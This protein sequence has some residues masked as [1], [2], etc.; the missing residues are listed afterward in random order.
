MATKAKTTNTGNKT[1]KIV[2]IFKGVGVETKR[3]RW[4][5]VSELL[6]N[7]VKVLVFCILFALFFVVCDLLVSE[8]LVLIG[9]GA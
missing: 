9:V 1:N 8:L 3:V 6:Q 7:T 5:K 4:P 2:D